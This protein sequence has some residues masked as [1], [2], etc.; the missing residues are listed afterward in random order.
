MREDIQI[1]IDYSRILTKLV[2]IEEHQLF[3]I[4][5]GTSLTPEEYLKK[6][7]YI[8]WGDQHRII[9]N[10][11]SFTNDPDLGLKVGQ[12]YPL[13]THGIGGVAA[14]A[15]ATLIEAIEVFIEYYP[16]RVQFL[17]VALAKTDSE[18]L[19]SIELL[20]EQDHVGKFL[21][22]TVLISMYSMLTTLI[23]YE[24]EDIGIDVM[25]EKPNNHE[26]YAKCLPGKI[27]YARDKMQF[28]IPIR[29]GNVQISTHD[30]RTLLWAQQQGQPVLQGLLSHRNYTKRVQ[31]ILREHLGTILSQEVVANELHVSGSTLARKLR[32][33]GT[34]FRSVVESEHQYMANHYLRNTDMTI[35]EI[36]EALGYF[37]TSSFRRAFKKWFGVPPSKYLSQ[38]SK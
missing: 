37:D 2:K 18:L 29:Y 24:V 12:Y 35:E 4:L 1:S 17:E 16:V 8:N 28:R 26:E 34:C 33:E 13:S 19:Y 32:E 30:S 10:V 6:E 23:G 15:S 36:G 27:Q 5:Q 3:H 7:G 21:T 20:V 31:A 38:Y 25:F 22:D 14:M 9:E 11:L